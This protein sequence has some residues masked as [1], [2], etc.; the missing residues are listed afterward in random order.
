MSSRT[1]RK[2]ELPLCPAE[3]T[4][5]IIRTGDRVRVTQPGEPKF[6]GRFVGWGL[7][8]ASGRAL[9]FVQGHSGGVGPFVADVTTLERDG[10]ES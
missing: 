1:K 8:A 9:L 2:R 6:V 3:R 4:P 5:G 10:G 7:D